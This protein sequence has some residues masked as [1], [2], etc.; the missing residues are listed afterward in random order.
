MSLVLRDAKMKCTN[1][2]QLRGLVNRTNSGI[3]VQSVTEHTFLHEALKEWTPQHHYRESGWMSTD[4]DSVKP[5][6]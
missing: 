1:R 4:D 5:P 6:L 2:S 3:N